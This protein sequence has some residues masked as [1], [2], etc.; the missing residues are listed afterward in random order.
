M[1][2]AYVDCAGVWRSARSP[3]REARYIPCGFTPIRRRGDLGMPDEG[4][5]EHVR[6]VGGGEAQDDWTAWLDSKAGGFSGV[7]L[8]ASGDVVQIVKA[9]GLADRSSVRPNTAETRFNLGSINKT[10]TALAGAQLLE[11]GRAAPGHTPRT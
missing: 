8:I 9:Y 6:H 3:T 11:Q 7:A 5:A 4:D 1:S 10:F 2:R